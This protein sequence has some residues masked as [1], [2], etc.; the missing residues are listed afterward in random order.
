MSE[1]WPAPG[2]GALA[3]IEVKK[4]RFLAIVRRATTADEARELVAEA[5]REYPGARHYCSAHVISEPGA[6]PIW[7]S[8]DDGEPA[9]TAGRPMLDVLVGSGLSNVAA[10]V[11]RWFGGTLL[12]TGGLVR[13]YSEATK[14]ALD[15][16][17]TVRVEMVDLWRLPVDHVTAGRVEAEL[18]D[19]GVTV[20]EVEYAASGVLLTLA[21]NN[22]DE[23]A[24]LVASVTAGAGELT[25]AGR[26]LV[27]Y[28][29]T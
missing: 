5:R 26:V 10:V 8:N 22:A 11:V 13:A 20:H 2:Q 9:Q 3:E 4:S 17:G 21:S 29:N 19:A 18:R 25:G 6:Q 28:S 14:L 1:R 7:H 16:L 15:A 27:E 23:L 12:G 24:R